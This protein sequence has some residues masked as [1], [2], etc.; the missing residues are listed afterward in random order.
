MTSGGASGFPF[1]AMFERRRSGDIVKAAVILCALAIAAWFAFVAAAPRMLPT[2]SI[3]RI[4]FLADHPEAVLADATRELVERR[5]IVP[6]R[7]LD[8]VRAA[9]RRAPLDARPYLIL[10]HQALLDR[11]NERALNI[12]EAGQRLDPRQRLI[13]VLLL[14]RYLREGKLDLAGQQFAVIARLVGEAQP[15]AAGLL[16]QMMLNPETRAAT[17]RTLRQDPGLERD[18][19][20]ALARTNAD[21]TLLFS[22]ASPEAIATATTA[23]SWGTM[24]LTRLVERGQIPQAR[25]IWRRLYAIPDNRAAELLYDPAIEG[26]P[27]SPPFNWSLAASSIGVADRQEGGIAVE[28]YGRESGELANQ[29]LV[30]PPGRYRLSF[31]AHA[32][33]A[34]ATDALTWNVACAGGTSSS[35]ASLPMASLGVAPRRYSA[36]FVVPTRCDGQRLALSGSGAEFASTTRATIT[37]L[38]ITAVR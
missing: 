26:W 14:D 15:Q 30:L 10:G 7:T 1:T 23:G 19:L 25:K 31:N 12:L 11:E 6:S 9:A 24:L 13:H 18:V 20:I 32:A 21:P 22:V 28:Y 4:T 35:L 37:R 27:G 33:A 17:L 2:P 34:P 16:A 3:R 5:G 38:S 8:M 36:E 29:I